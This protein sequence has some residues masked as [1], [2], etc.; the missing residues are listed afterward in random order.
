MAVAEKLQNATFTGHLE[1]PG[2]T[3]CDL[4]YRFGDPTGAPLPS[5][6]RLQRQSLGWPCSANVVCVTATCSIPALG[7]EREDVIVSVDPAGIDGSLRML[8]QSLE[9]PELGLTVLRL[10]PDGQQLSGG[11]ESWSIGD[12]LLISATRREGPSPP[13]SPANAKVPQRPP[14]APGPG[15]GSP[16]A[17]KA[18]VTKPSAPQ[19]ARRPSPGPSPSKAQASPPASTRK[20]PKANFYAEYEPPYEP[21]LDDVIGGEGLG[22]PIPFRGVSDAS[23]RLAAVQGGGRVESEFLLRPDELTGGEEPRK[24]VDE[25]IR[26]AEEGSIERLLAAAGAGETGD[27][28]MLLARLGPDRAAATGRHVGLTP[29]MVAAERGRVEVLTLLIEKR[30]DLEVR[31]PSGWTALMHAIQGQRLDAVRL[32]LDSRASVNVI[33]KADGAFTP[34]ALAAAGAR[35]DLCSLLLN[36]GARTETKDEEGRKAIH[37]AAKRGNGAAL[38]ALLSAR[39]Q[40]EDRDLAGLTPLLLAT[41]AGRAESVKILLANG[42]DAFAQDLEGRSAIK[43]ASIYEHE[44]VLRVLQEAGK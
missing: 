33:S 34:L 24:A 17:A 4:I 28:K 38:V 13:T 35:P 6:V 32:L 18:K 31:D 23:R 3:K 44:R 19:V 20:E 41:S 10:S 21:G 14:T 2:A 5:Q 15:I 16:K 40:M 11:D 1:P 42:A 9:R 37:H 7:I 22:R 12:P 39:A 29:L 27:V 8:I 43:L 26:A 25:E 30:A 36:V